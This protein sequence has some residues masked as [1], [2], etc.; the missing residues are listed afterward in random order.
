MY[1]HSLAL[2]VSVMSEY[3]IDFGVSSRS[4]DKTT[5]VMGVANMERHVTARTPG[6]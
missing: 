2:S 6:A 3:T 1:R 5:S 4:C